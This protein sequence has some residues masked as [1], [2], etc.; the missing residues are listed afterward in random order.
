MFL[1]VVSA[2]ASA[3]NGILRVA[4]NSECS[5]RPAAAFT[6]DI[7]VKGLETGSRVPIAAVYC[8]ET[9]RV[10]IFIGGVGG[11]TLTF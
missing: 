5:D 9:I 3:H 6:I 4:C 11:K 8:V 1:P 7:R 10:V 2:M